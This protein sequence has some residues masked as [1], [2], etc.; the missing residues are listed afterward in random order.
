MAVAETVLITGNTFPVKDQ[1]KAL[2]G[3]AAKWDSVNKG[4]LVP[5]DKAEQVKAIVAAGAGSAGAPK[6][7][8]KPFRHYKCKVCGVQASRYVRIYGSGECRDCYEER[9]MGY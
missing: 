3:S 4:W 6:T 8:S 5:A 7:E 1:I 9:K 2:C